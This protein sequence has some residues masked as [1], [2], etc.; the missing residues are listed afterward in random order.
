LGGLG[1]RG[2]DL[3][4][5]DEG[6]RQK[7]GGLERASRR[8]SAGSFAVAPLEIVGDA[9]EPVRCA[10]SKNEEKM[11]MS[12]LVE[13]LEE[14]LGGLFKALVGL[15]IEG[16][17]VFD[18]GRCDVAPGRVPSEEDDDI[19]VAVF[20]AVLDDVVFTDRVD[21]LDLNPVI[22][23]AV[24]NEDVGFVSVIEDGRE[25]LPTVLHQPAYDGAFVRGLLHHDVGLAF[26]LGDSSWHGWW[27]A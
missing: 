27:V 21:G 16:S 9:E 6:E 17:F 14:L 22:V 10:P 25:D 8:A 15:V 19:A 13:G 5:A 18:K 11:R 23:R 3:A 2:F 4:E 12:E 7:T 20:P 1:F 24:G 26:G